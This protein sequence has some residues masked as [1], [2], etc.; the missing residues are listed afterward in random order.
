M[1]TLFLSSWWSETSAWVTTSKSLRW[2][3][4]PS[5][6]PRC[7]CPT[8][9][10]ASALAPNSCCRTN[11]SSASTRTHWGCKATARGRWATPVN[12]CGLNQASET[13][14]A[15]QVDGF[16]VWER[17]LSKQRLAI[18]VLNTQEIGGPRGFVIRAAPGWRVC[19]PACNVTQILP[20]YKDMG[21][22]PTY[23]KMVL[24]VNPSGTVLLTV[25]PVSDFKLYNME[26]Q[27]TPV[28]HQN[29]AFL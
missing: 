29:N 28:K 5:W 15:P 6:R 24:R 2:R 1:L 10:G 14:L 21:V 3:Y 25:T 12:R 18:A 17:P 27:D 19:K 4:G 8:T 16:E 22:Q 11:T 20:Q 9:W 7:S 23:S 26:W 13:W